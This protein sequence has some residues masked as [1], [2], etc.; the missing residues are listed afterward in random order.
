MPSTARRSGV[1]PGNVGQLA[2]CGAE[3]TMSVTRSKRTC[4]PAPLRPA[5]MT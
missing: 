3:A 4:G 2:P 1:I 5:V